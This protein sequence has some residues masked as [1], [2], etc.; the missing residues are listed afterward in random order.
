M[1]LLY[2]YLRQRENYDTNTSDYVVVV[3]A[4][5]VSTARFVTKVTHTHTK[6]TKRAAMPAR[7][8]TNEVVANRAGAAPFFSL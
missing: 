5:F 8:V 4:R 7:F 6:V 3:V 1:F 2:R